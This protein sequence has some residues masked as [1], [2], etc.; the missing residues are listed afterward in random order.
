MPPLRG[1]MPWVDWTLLGVLAGGFAYGVATIA[2]RERSLPFIIRQR[3]ESMDFSLHEGKDKDKEKEE[4]TFTDARHEFNKILM[5]LME[6]REEL[7]EKARL[8]DEKEA[9]EAEAK[10]IER[11]LAIMKSIQDAAEKEALKQKKEADEYAA[12]KEK[13]RVELESFKERMDTKRKEEEERLRVLEVEENSARIADEAVRQE[14]MLA[15]EA[16]RNFE[17]ETQVET[18]SEGIEADVDTQKELEQR[19]EREGAKSGEV[20]I[21]LMWNDRN[22]LD[23]HVLCP[24]G[25]RIH[26][27]NRDSKC[28]GELDVD[29]NVRA[30]SKRP[31]ESVVWGEGAP[32]G[33]YKAYVHFYKH[34]SKRRTKKHSRFTVIVNAGGEVKEYT[35]SLSLGDPIKHIAEFS[36]PELNQRIGYEPETSLERVKLDIENAST[37]EEYQDID[38]EGIPAGLKLVWEENIQRKILDL[39]NLAEQEAKEARFED[40][41][42]MLILATSPEEIED[43]DFTV[44][45]ED[46]TQRLNDILEGNIDVQQ[47]TKYNELLE[48][49]T[50]ATRATE[51]QGTIIS[52]VNDEQRALLKETKDEVLERFNTSLFSEAWG[53]IDA[54]STSEELNEIEFVG[55]NE[56][57][58]KSLMEHL[59][60]RFLEL[61]NIES[62][63]DIIRE[64]D[65]DDEDEITLTDEFKEVLSETLVGEDNFEEASEMAKELHTVIEAETI[66]GSITEE[67]LE[68]NEGIEELPVSVP[69]SEVPLQ[70]EGES[71]VESFDDLLRE[72][73]APAEKLEAESDID[74]FE[75]PLSDEVEDTLSDTTAEELDTPEIKNNLEEALETIEGIEES[76]VSVPVSEESL[77]TEEGESEV[78]SFDDL[79]KELDAPVAELET[80]SDI[81]E[82]EPPQSVEVEDTFS[83]TPAEELDAPENED[84][85][86]KTPETLEVIEEVPVSE[87][88]LQTEEGESEVESL[89]DLLGKLEE[90]SDIDEVESPL[91]DEVEDTLS[92]TTAEELDAPVDELEA[93]PDIDEV[94]SPLSDEVEDTLSDTTA[95]ELETPETPLE[96]IKNKIANASTIEEYQDIDL[97]GIPAGLKQVWKENIQRNIDDLEETELAIGEISPLPS[98]DEAGKFDLLPI[99]SEMKLSSALVEELDKRLKYQGTER[100]DWEVSLIWNNKNDLDLHL[101]TPAGNI[102][103]VDAQYSPCGGQL[104]AAM[105]S[106]SASKKPIEHIIWHSKPPVGTYEVSVDHFR[107]RLG[108]GTRDPTSFVVV[109]NRKGSLSCW[110][111]EI[112]SSEPTR[113][114]FKF[115]I[116]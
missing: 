114:V 116:H 104:V 43:I 18:E 44:F 27:G 16:Q 50:T 97:E 80:E 88:S 92:D 63:D 54:A 115:E 81:G 51:I 35:D 66:E 69:V 72:L 75:T 109:L 53:R 79:L 58:M 3:E 12:R 62:F 103:N 2:I 37:I 26:G 1:D 100:A 9:A 28:G 110:G 45:D 17:V 31:V 77:Q 93:E 39:E 11:K 84:N 82:V 40:V 76:T 13:E 59:Q 102:I 68:T 19:L 91:S 65:I 41:K 64:S 46:E 32:P 106:K 86:G 96:R 6:K 8:R 57:Q 87:E 23:L 36:M 21:S 78:E 22:D 5:E 101:S 38:L 48:R 47:A 60:G 90:E 15:M 25:E 107:K 95:E 34:H 55:I 83:D 85:L 99:G 10:A 113:S 56:E 108:L 73:D 4:L 71:E 29:M 94:E 24:S 42:Q 33:V 74:E 30:E 7:L 89:E 67:T 20:Q 70:T 98:E 49:I 14:N 111:G 112:S 61:Q 105:N 52:G